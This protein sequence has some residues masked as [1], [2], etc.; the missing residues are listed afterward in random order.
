MVRWRTVDAL[1]GLVDH[2]DGYAFA[3]SPP[4]TH[5]G[6]SSRYLTVVLTLDGPLT[7]TALPDPLQAPGSY[8]ALV[9]GLHSR[10]AGIA[11]GGRSAGIQLALIPAG[12]RALLGRPAAELG[13]FVLPLSDVLGADAERLLDRLREASGWAARF[14][15]LDQ[16]LASRIVD[17]PAAVRPEVAWA[18]DCLLIRRGSTPVAALAAEVGWSRRHLTARFEREFGLTPKVTARVLRFES[19]VGRLRSSPHQRLADVAADCGYADQAHMTR[20]WRG[21]AGCPPS[22][23]LAEEFAYVL[24]GH[25]AEKS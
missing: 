5:R 16:E 12:A 19:S 25:T 3:D 17:R 8:D 24:V 4:G 13:G 23:W 1:R 22:T 11:M 10:P 18:W 20:E 7:M 15:L 2:Y 21:L 6:L 14:R 9:G